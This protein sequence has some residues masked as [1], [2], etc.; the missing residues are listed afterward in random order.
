MLSKQFHYLS[1]KHA[2]STTNHSTLCTFLN[3]STTVYRLFEFEKHEIQYGHI[4]S[5]WPGLW[6]AAQG[7][8]CRFTGGYFWLLKLLWILWA[9]P[10]WLKGLTPY[11]GPQLWKQ[12][13]HTLYDLLKDWSLLS[14]IFL[15]HNIESCMN[16]ILVISLNNVESQIPCLL[17]EPC[18]VLPT[19]AIGICDL[20]FDHS[21]W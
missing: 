8:L 13:T 2:T 10:M 15:R 19:A 4:W 16:A 17:K 3:H 21:T 5:L 18:A 20:H 12:W 11:L 7:L 6:P 9:Q 14:G 1:L